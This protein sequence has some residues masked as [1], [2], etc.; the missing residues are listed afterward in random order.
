MLP[1]SPGPFLQKYHSNTIPVHSCHS[2]ALR[3][4]SGQSSCKIGFVCRIKCFNSLAEGG[5]DETKMAGA[6]IP[7][8]PLF[9]KA[10]NYWVV[11]RGRPRDPYLLSAPTPSNHPGAWAGQV[12]LEGQLGNKESPGCSKQLPSQSHSLGELSLRWPGI[13]PS[14]CLGLLLKRAL[15]TLAFTLR[16][17]GSMTATISLLLPIESRCLWDILQTPWPGI[18]GL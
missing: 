17:G 6:F 1:P 10:E 11:G 4:A 15:S 9:A 5:K 16:G 14:R 18:Q 2:S 7:D 3:Q 13:L 12:P 8:G